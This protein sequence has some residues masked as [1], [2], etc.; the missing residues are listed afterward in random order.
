MVRRLALNAEI[1]S[2]RLGVEGAALNVVMREVGAM[3]ATLSELVQAAEQIFQAPFDGLMGPLEVRKGSLLEE[4]ELLTTLADN[5]EMWVYFNVT[6]SEYLDYQ[7]RVGEKGEATVQLQLAN[8]KRFKHGG[9]ITAIEADFN[10]ETGNIAFRATFPNPDGL[11]RHGETGNVLL[12]TPL[13]D[14]LL[15]PQKA[16]YDILD[17]KFVYV[18]DEDGIVHAREITVA[19]ELPHLYVVRSGLSEG[20]RILLEGLRKVRD[21]VEIGHVYEEPTA[22]ITE[23]DIHAE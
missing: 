18:V 4:G 17:K 9:Q 10:N 11:L 20:D 3:T 2:P 23:L 5:S 7:E 22:V 8:D 19:E 6:E 15:I 13:D 16:T 12:S 1:A 21:G 14:V